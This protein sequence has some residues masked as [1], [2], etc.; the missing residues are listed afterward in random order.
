MHRLLIG[1]VV[2][3]M[4]L[5]GA[6][7]PEDPPS[8]E[9]SGMPFLTKGPDNR[10]YLSWTDDL[11]ENGHALRYS[12]WMG[13]GWSAP[14]TIAEGEHWFVNW[15][16]FPSLAVSRD[17]SM[18]AHWLARAEHGGKYGYGIHVA[19]RDAQ[20]KQWKEIHGMSIDETEDYAGFLHFVNSPSGTGA[21]YLSPPLEKT[22]QTHG[23]SQ[24]SAGE[25]TGHQHEVE[26]RK[27]LRFVQFG[28]GGDV[29]S[30]QLLDADVCSCCQTTAGATSRGLLV[31]YR[32]HR[33]NEIR[34][35]S[36]A[37]LENGRWSEP[38]LLHPDGWQINACPTDGP[39]LAVSGKDVAIAWYTRAQNQ[40]RVQV[41]LSSDS[42]VHFGPTV[43]LDNG[44]P[45]GRPTITRL[46]AT[47]F[48]AT[49]LERAEAGG[50]EVRMRCVGLDGK[51]SESVTVARLAAARSSGFPKVEVSGDQ[52]I[53]A[54]RDGRVKAAILD[55]KTFAKVH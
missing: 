3:V 23:A 9:G 41:A 39:S 30:D 32:D 28:R 50:A 47:N 14:E 10:V 25:T 49:W 11:G 4:F 31:A 55:R 43:R 12:R 24:P 37:R 5:A 34:D 52:I 33:P 18:Y 16:D 48:L 27:T 21:V 17:G 51:L 6:G 8:G 22:T 54:W 2:F 20:G 42:G 15:A 44:N 1:L 45:L 19:R 38:S 29:V 35:I 7:V 36:V 46:D 26:H 53:V 40:P 13:E